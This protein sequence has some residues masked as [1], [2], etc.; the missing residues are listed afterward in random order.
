MMNETNGDKY[1]I[2]KQRLEQHG[3]TLYKVAHFKNF[4]RIH[5]GN[6][7]IKI[8]INLRGKL[9]ELALDAIINACIGKEAES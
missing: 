5:F 9:A 7:A 2:L 4:D 3:Y 1:P 8:S 6:S